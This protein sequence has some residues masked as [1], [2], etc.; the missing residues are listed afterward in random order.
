MNKN[1][2]LSIFALLL[3]ATSVFADGN[4]NIVESSVSTTGNH[5]NTAGGSFTVQNLGTTQ[6]NNILLTVSNLQGSSQTIT[7]SAVQLTPTSVNLG[8][9]LSTSP[10]YT[11]NIPSLQ[12]AGSYTG[13]LTATYNA[14]DFDTASFTVTVNP[15]PA[16]SIQP[17]SPS[18]TVGSSGQLILTVKN[19]GNTN[20][21]N[22]PYT[23]T[24]TLTHANGIDT[25][26]PAESVAGTTTINYVSPSVQGQT[27]IP[28]TFNI[29]A[30]KPTG[31]Y[32]GTF[33]LNIGTST[34]TQAVTVTVSP[35]P[36]TSS[37]I[38]PEVQYDSSERDTTVQKQIIVYNNGATT[39]TGISL[40][41]SAPNTSVSG[42]PTTL[43]PGTSST[44]TVSTYI[45][46]SMDSGVKQIGSLNFYSNQVTATSAVKTNAVSKLTFDKVE[47]SLAGGAFDS[48][49]SSGDSTDDEARPMDTYDVRVVME[50]QFSSSSNIGI[51]DITVTAVF[52]GVSE[53]GNDND[54]ET[55]TF[56]VD[57][58]ESSD[59]Q[60]IEWDEDNTIDVES[61]DGDH[62]IVL[63]AEGED[64]NGAIHKAT[65]TVIVEVKREADV[66]PTITDF[67]VYPQT[68]GCS[69]SFTIRVEGM[70][71]GEDS[72]KDAALEI[73]SSSL[74]ISVKEEFEL[75]DYSD[76]DCNA[77]EE[78]EDSCREF[79]Y[80]R[81]FS[82]PS[83]V[84]SGTY[85]I[86]ARFLY[87][88]TR[89][90][91]SETINLVVNCG[92]TS[93]TTS[94]TSGT[95]SGTSGTTTG[96]SGT[97]ATTSGTSG[98]TSGTSGTTTGT[99]SYYTTPGYTTGTRTNE[100]QV[101]YTT[102]PTAGTGSQVSA[103]TVSEPVHITDTTGQKKF[104]DSTA[105]IMLL[106][107]ANLAVLAIIL[108][109]FSHIGRN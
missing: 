108:A 80:D 55:E 10:Q 19:T 48:V 35:I 16:A 50:N 104:T 77:I 62:E 45:P 47:V 20:L 109:L 89:E 86:K 24:G 93:G 9:G 95:T 7:T 39:L 36:G 29:P 34:V 22:A 70:N 100:V 68:I 21:V 97:S 53:D 18:I 78:P 74:S 87:D 57:E 44:V 5:G 65:F 71:I 15:S 30:A 76:D 101:L 105:F 103:A 1:I 99:G 63:T 31:T 106:V 72:D 56:D 6:L 32:T 26:T 81:S 67:S 96:T 11:V 40:T 83:S 43:A 52:E 94:G 2:L 66:D 73:T 17:N 102:T 59:A 85:A 98:T 54:G 38:L 33:S 79:S 12:F 107:L 14:T 27:T 3:L 4:V 51:E 49:S 13:T 75:G 88:T 46:K 84:K 42:M 64:E 25:I 28:F 61:D 90:G 8:A 58:D 41:T 69:D 37:V 92:T 82:I 91:D 60:E 23:L